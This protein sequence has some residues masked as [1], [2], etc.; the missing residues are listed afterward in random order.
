M[1]QTR[2][3]TGADKVAFQVQMA[4][5]QLAKAETRL[6]AAKERSRAAKRR[7]KAAK[8]AARQARKEVKK[9]KADVAVC[10]DA[11][12][13]SEA[14]LATAG[15]QLT[16]KEPKAGRSRKATAPEPRRRKMPALAEEAQPVLAAS[17]AEASGM[18]SAPEAPP[19]QVVSDAP[20][21]TV[22]PS[23]GGTDLEKAAT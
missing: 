7:R 12:V 11:L 21:E 4:R 13:T 20:T 2:R 14:S 23:S 8:E 10:K 1:G 18:P 17:S 6:E 16:R 9:A 19:S 22:I 5:V 15:A 3:P